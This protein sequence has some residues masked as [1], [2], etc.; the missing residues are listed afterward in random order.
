[1]RKIFLALSLF[2]SFSYIY[3][4]PYRMAIGARFGKFNNGA[5]IK[6]F[7]GTDNG[8]A[9]EGQ[10]YYSKVAD[11]YGYTVKGF[12]LDQVTFKIPFVQLPLDFFFGAGLQAGYFPYDAPGYYKI[13]D[14]KA[15]YY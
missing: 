8:M 12:L 2:F 6:Q 4:Q 11:T 15:D 7:L 1:M 10:L 5:T 3:A 13:V 9:W 14:G